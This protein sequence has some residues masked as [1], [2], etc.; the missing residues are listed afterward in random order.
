MFRVVR[1]STVDKLTDARLRSAALVH[2]LEQKLIEAQRTVDD[3]KQIIER[4]AEW[5]KELRD[6]VSE[7]RVLLAR[8]HFR[9]PKTGRISK[10][11]ALPVTKGELQ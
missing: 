8:A 5:V 9:D 11:G 2:D 4:Q 6:S 3:C 7:H 10:A 1:K